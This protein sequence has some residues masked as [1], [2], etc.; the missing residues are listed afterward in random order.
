[1]ACST[2]EKYLRPVRDD[3]DLHFQARRKRRAVHLRHLLELLLRAEPPA[4]LQRLAEGGEVRGLSTHLSRLLG[5]LQNTSRLPEA[6]CARYRYGL[7]EAQARQAYPL[8]DRDWQLAHDLAAE[9]AWD[10]PAQAGTIDYERL[11]WHDALEESLVAVEVVLDSRALEQMLV[12]CLEG[13]LSPRL[14]RRKGYEVYG[15]CLGM[16]RQ[17]PP[18]R[19]RTQPRI[20]RYLSVLQAHPQ[21]SAQSGYHSVEPNDASFR[22]ILQ[23]TRAMYPQYLAIGDFH[24]HPYDDRTSLEARKG[25]RFTDADEQSNIQLVESLAQHAQR[26][27]VSFVVALAR[28]AGVLPRGH[29]RR[30]CHTLQL[31]IG[32]CRVVLGAFRS[33]GSGRLTERNLRLRLA[34]VH[35]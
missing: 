22:A 33:L 32:G 10:L 29:F 30:Q 17:T 1:M 16:V 6:L 3:L 21:L 19:T 24:S 35:P 27:H 2:L 11:V 18:R 25:W 13:Y 31:S 9:V 12:S 34:G 8:P 4:A 23:A 5:H 14:P 15:L 20:T 26:F 28:C 7:S